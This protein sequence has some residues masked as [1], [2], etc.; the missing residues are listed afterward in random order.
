M[1]GRRSK[2]GEEIAVTYVNKVRSESDFLNIRTSPV[3]FNSMDA[4]RSDSSSFDADTLYVSYR[5]EEIVKIWLP[6][7]LQISLLV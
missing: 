2:L 6:T 3:S 4:C 5:P 7:F 1:A